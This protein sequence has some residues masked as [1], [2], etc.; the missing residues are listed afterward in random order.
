MKVEISSDECE[1]ELTRAQVKI[2]RLHKVIE[3]IQREAFLAT[4]SPTQRIL[5][6]RVHMIERM[7]HNALKALKDISE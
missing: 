7:A 1:S 3:T 4:S 5:V 2:I 6:D